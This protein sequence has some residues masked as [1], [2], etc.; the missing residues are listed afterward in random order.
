M[1]LGKLTTENF[2]H[3]S[4][5][6]YNNYRCATKEEFEED[7][8]HIRY[9]R[10]LLR[11]YRD[12]GKIDSNRLRLTLNHFIILYNVFRADLVTRMIFFKC[13]PSL[14]GMVRTFLEYLKY[15]PKIV[16]D[17]NSRDIDSKAL[18]IDYEI[19]DR[20]RRL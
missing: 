2:D 12:T 7:L 15:M 10:R 19:L 13:E 20:L 17:I 5:A 9:L 3:F 1:E 8:G 18:P 4:L 16:V 6:A 11:K 14:H